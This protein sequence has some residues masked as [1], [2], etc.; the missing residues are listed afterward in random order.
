MK[1]AALAEAG[2]L[3]NER[4]LGILAADED[5]RDHKLAAVRFHLTPPTTLTSTTAGKQCLPGIETWSSPALLTDRKLQGMHLCLMLLPF[6]LS[7]DFDSML[8][9]STVG[10]N[11]NFRA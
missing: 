5:V 7:T 2:D 4:N 9:L 11:L 10:R 6:R 8:P 3:Q 1:A